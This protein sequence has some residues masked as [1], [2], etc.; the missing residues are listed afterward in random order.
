M[1]KESSNDY[2]DPQRSEDGF[3]S[4]DREMLWGVGAATANS[5]EADH[6]EFSQR[7]LR[8]SKR[9]IEKAERGFQFL[10]NAPDHSEREKLYASTIRGLFA[11]VKLLHAFIEADS[12]I[13]ARSHDRIDDL[14]KEVVR[15]N[16]SRERLL[17]KMGGVDL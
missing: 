10:A 16:E 2:C 1:H 11:E 5:I 3:D 12:R 8:I 9:A 7:G 15:L 4:R 17:E 13:I 14:Q 6:Q